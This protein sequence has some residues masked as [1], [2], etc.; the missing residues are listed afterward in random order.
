MLGGEWGVN[1]EASPVPMALASAPVSELGSCQLKWRLGSPGSGMLGKE[2]AVSLVE[3]QDR[4]RFPP[5]VALETGGGRSQ[6]LCFP[7]LPAGWTGSAQKPEERR[8]R[9]LALAG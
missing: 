7:V 9:E 1:S 5:Y 2:P 3:G 6:L 4:A 8:G